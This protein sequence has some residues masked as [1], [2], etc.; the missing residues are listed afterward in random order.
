[1]DDKTHAELLAASI[2][3]PIITAKFDELVQMT[4]EEKQ[5]YLLSTI[6]FSFAT[7]ELIMKYNRRERPTGK[8]FSPEMN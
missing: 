6:E 2:L 8:P 5:S 3:G 7:A 1:M 4:A